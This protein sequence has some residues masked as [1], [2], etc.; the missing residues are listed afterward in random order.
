MS[1]KR[2]PKRKTKLPNSLKDTDYEL[3]SK[4]SNDT[5][6]DET[7]IDGNLGEKVESR[8]DDSKG[9]KKVDRRQVEDVECLISDGSSVRDKGCLNTGEFPTIGES[10]GKKGVSMSKVGCVEDN[11]S[12]VENTGVQKGV[13]SVNDTDVNKSVD[14]TVSNTVPLTLCNTE[15]NNSECN[16]TCNTSDNNEAMENGNGDI[17]NRPKTFVDV[18]NAIA[19]SLGNPLIMDKVTA[20]MCSEGTGNIGFARVLV[21]IKADREF[22]DKIEIC[23]KGNGQMIKNSKFVDVEYSWKPPRCSHCKVYGHN[24][25]TCRM[26]INVESVDSDKN[27][28]SKETNNRD[29]PKEVKQGNGS[30]GVTQNKGFKGFKN[31]MEYKP[32]K[33]KPNTDVNTQA[34]DKHENKLDTE[35]HKNTMGSNSPGTPKNSWKVDKSAIE[36]LRRSANKYAVLEEIDENE[37]YGAKW[38]DS[39]DKYVKYQRQ[40]SKEEAKLWTDEMHKYFKEQWSEIWDKECVEEDVYK[41]ENGMAKS[42]TLNELNGNESDILHKGNHKNSLLCQH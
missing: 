1:T 42:M 39:V 4:R 17:D 8:V 35:N 33:K 2:R 9:S 41:E 18:T 23:Y 30:K 10:M 12:N 38:K 13:Q 16:G 22:K 21:E 14:C 28:Q 3:L 25:S 20:K 27:N 29:G 15:V 34:K 26:R 31:R 19:S 24:D 40:P 6:Y 7:E 5:K 11:G 36:E 32:V 37:V